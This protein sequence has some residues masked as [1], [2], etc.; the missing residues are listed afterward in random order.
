MP[1]PS[2]RTSTG[3]RRSC[4]SWRGKMLCRPTCR[5][6]SGSPKLSPTGPA[7]ILWD[8]PLTAPD[9]DSASRY[10]VY[11]FDHTPALPGDLADARNM[12]AVV[13]ARQFI[14]PTPPASGS[15]SYVVTALDRNYNES[16]PSNILVHQSACRSSAGI[17]CKRNCW[18]SPRACLVTGGSLHWPR[19]IICRC[20]RIL[21]SRPDVRCKRFHNCRY[22]DDGP[23][24]YG[25][26]P[27][28][29]GVCARRT[30]RVRQPTRIRSAFTSGF[31]PA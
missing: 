25:T 22:C 24:I 14:P 1:I 8:L 16:E 4:R 12:L 29:T 10:A 9:G 21:R 17:A 23:R 7:T 26:A 27:L 20:R 30:G 31:P 3:T 18:R 19:P 5:G 28:S 11:R 2:K 6:T 15:Y 13:G